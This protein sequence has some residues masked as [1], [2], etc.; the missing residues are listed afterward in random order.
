MKSKQTNK[1]E[2]MQQMQMYV[3]TPEQNERA[4]EWI[5]AQGNDKV[6]QAR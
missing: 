4:N 6:L 2:N 1:H 3:S 5:N